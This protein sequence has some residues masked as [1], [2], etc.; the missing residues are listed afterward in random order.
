MLTY[1][2]VLQ[3][4]PHLLISKNTLLSP[5]I[6]MLYAVSW[7]TLHYYSN[8]FCFLMGEPVTKTVI[9][10]VW[11]FQNFKRIIWADKRV[12]KS[13]VTIREMISSRNWVCSQWHVANPLIFPPACCH[14]NKRLHCQFLWKFL[15]SNFVWKDQIITMTVNVEM[16]FCCSFHCMLHQIKETVRNL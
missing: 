14:W 4:W 6:M 10:P 11:L 13:M 7:I 12:N 16:A 15:Y 2:L 1:K 3:S 8:G 9:W 5:G